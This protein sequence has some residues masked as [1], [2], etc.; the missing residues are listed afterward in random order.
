MRTQDIEIGVFY[1][2]RLNPYHGFAKA[3]KII[4][5]TAK[6]KNNGLTE[7]ERQLKVVCVKCEWTRWKDDTFGL[8]KYF[9]PC[10]LVKE[11]PHGN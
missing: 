2:H 11:A 4:K 5:P 10:D 6:Y 9:R 3:L 8:I 1:R 7:E